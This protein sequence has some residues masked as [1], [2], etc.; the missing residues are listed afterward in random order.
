MKAHWAT[1]PFRASASTVNVDVPVPID[2]TRI[3][4]LGTSKHAKAST[5][6]FMMGLLAQIPPSIIT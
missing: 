6:A 3:F 4:S 1:P 2:K 5:T